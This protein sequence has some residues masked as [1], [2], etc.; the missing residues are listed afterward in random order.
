MVIIATLNNAGELYDFLKMM[1]DRTDAGVRVTAKDID[2]QFEAML[3]GE[4]LLVKP[5]GGNEFLLTPDEVVRDHELFGLS[6]AE[7]S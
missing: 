1:H 2:G 7:L 5:D 4:C 6:S 3:S